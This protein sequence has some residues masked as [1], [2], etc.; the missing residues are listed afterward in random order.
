MSQKQVKGRR[1]EGKGMQSR[2]R[3]GEN[4]GNDFWDGFKKEWLECKNEECK[5]WMSMKVPDGWK[6][7]DENEKL[8]R[9]MEQM[10]KEDDKRK[11]AGVYECIVVFG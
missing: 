1:K 6:G 4:D 9:D 8:K 10:K 2:V 7:G 5:I 11:E 3:H